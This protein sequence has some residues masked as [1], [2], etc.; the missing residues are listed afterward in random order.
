M[1]FDKLNRD[2]LS[3]VIDYAGCFDVKTMCIVFNIDIEDYGQR[4]DRY[5]LL[6][7]N[8]VCGRRAERLKF[9]KK[10]VTPFTFQEYLNYFNLC[11]IEYRN[12]AVPRKCAGI[13]HLNSKQLKKLPVFGRDEAF[14]RYHYLNSMHFRMKYSD[15]YDIIDLCVDQYG[16]YHMLERII[17]K[18]ERSRNERLIRMQ[19]MRENN[20]KRFDT[21]LE[22]IARAHD[23]TFEELINHNIAYYNSV[24]HHIYYDYTLSFFTRSARNVAFHKMLNKRY[25]LSDRQRS[26]ISN[27]ALFKQ[28]MN[29]IIPY[30]KKNCLETIDRI[31]NQSLL[32]E[33]IMWGG[34]R[35]IPP[36][37]LVNTPV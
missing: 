36:I 25:H 27:F 7:D 5:R 11:P 30:S 34:A 21:E 18:C 16:R 2:L 17:N 22:G 33:N 14:R 4:H 31:Y 13:W 10:D 37:L 12:G 35:V 3:L 24:C 9:R 29:G 32:Y 19:T 8:N 6:K 20:K 23:I 15:L 26:S 1:P 28:W